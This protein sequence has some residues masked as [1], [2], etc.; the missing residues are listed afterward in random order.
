MGASGQ[1]AEREDDDESQEDEKGGPNRRL[2]KGVHRV[3]DAASRHEC[4]E[5]GD[6]ERCDDEAERPGRGDPAP[7]VD[8]GGVQVRGGEQPGHERRIFNRV[9]RPVATPTEHIV[10]PPAAEDDADGQA[11]PGY[12]HP[13]AQRRAPGVI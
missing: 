3:E 4:S 9:P 12:E 11:Q 1:R 7:L 8:E 2:R 6:G 5:H 13:A 10:G